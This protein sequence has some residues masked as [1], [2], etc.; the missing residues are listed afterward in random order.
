MFLF[1]PFL[2]PPAIWSLA[3]VTAPA[4]VPSPAGCPITDDLT[5]TLELEDDFL[6]DFAVVFEPEES[7][8]AM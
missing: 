4:A 2:L 7:V 5:S 6:S 8:L 3:H 1:K